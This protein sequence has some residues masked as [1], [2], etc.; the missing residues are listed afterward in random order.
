MVAARV[1]TSWSLVSP[2]SRTRRRI[3]VITAA[4]PL[5][6]AGIL[7]V[8]VLL[9]PYPVVRLRPEAAA[10]L[11]L[12]DR[13]GELLRD[14]PLPGRGR[15]TWVSLSEVAPEVILATLISE[16]RHFHTHHGVDVTAVLRSLWLDLRAHKVVSG[17]STITMQLV[18]LVDPERR[19]LFAK[20][21]EMRS[22]S[23]PPT[24]AASWLA[25]PRQCLKNFTN[26]VFRSS[27]KPFIECGNFSTTNSGTH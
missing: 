24:C 14:S 6:V 12:V 13:H 21:G 19:G 10:S 15:E 9:V 16:D 1:D 11:R 5:T 18:R 25:L 27:D 3:L 23:L 17:A 8:A 7:A 4:L 20:M 26:R 2:M 22:C